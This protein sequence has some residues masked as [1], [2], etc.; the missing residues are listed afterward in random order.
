MQ[1]VVLERERDE[2]QVK[3]SATDRS[4]ERIATACERQSSG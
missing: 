3:L 1:K 4:P 2:L